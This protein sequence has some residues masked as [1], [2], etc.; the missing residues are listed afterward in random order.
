MKPVDLAVRIVESE[1]DELWQKTYDPGSVVEY[2][3][4]SSLADALAQFVYYVE[5][6]CNPEDYDN[7]RRSWALQVDSMNEKFKKYISNKM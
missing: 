6:T 5:S 7:F 4:G 3:R 1:A 2:T